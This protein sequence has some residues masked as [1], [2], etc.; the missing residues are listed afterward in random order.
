MAIALLQYDWHRLSPLG[1]LLLTALT[2]YGPVGVFGLLYYVILERVAFNWDR[3]RNLQG[4]LHAVEGEIAV[5]RAH[6]RAPRLPVLFRI[7]RIVVHYAK[8]HPTSLQIQG[9]VE[10]AIRPPWVVEG[11]ANWHELRDGL[12][13]VFFSG[14]T[15]LDRIAR[16][17]WLLSLLL[18]VAVALQ[19][20]PSIVL[21]GA[22]LLGCWL[23]LVFVL[24]RHSG[25]VALGGSFLVT[26][27]FL[28]VMI[29]VGRVVT[30][31]PYR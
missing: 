30:G 10:Q 9:L 12:K 24:R 13:S 5:A 1:R 11:G 27:I 20:E 2:L 14:Q 18:L 25:I 22:A 17:A 29:L 7:R 21:G 8:D 26:M 28:C 23:S 31:S 19:R 3:E 6:R 16:G 15:L 4:F